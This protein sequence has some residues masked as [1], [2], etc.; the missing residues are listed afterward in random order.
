M[1]FGMQM[2]LNDDEIRKIFLPNNDRISK[3]TYKKYACD[4]ESDVHQYIMNRYA[5][6][7]SFKESVYRICWNIQEEHPRCKVC[8]KLVAIRYRRKD[9]YRT[10]CCSFCV[11]HDKG[12]LKKKEKTYFE[13]TGYTHNSRN[14]ESVNKAKETCKEKY[15]TE[16][17]CQSDLVKSKSMKTCLNRYGVKYGGQSK[18]KIQKVKDTCLKKYGYE[19]SL[20]NNKVQEKRKQTCKERLGV[21]WPSQNQEVK[22]KLS[23]IH[24]SM[25]C[26]LKT[27]ETKRK[28]KTFNSSHQEQELFDYIKERFQDVKLQY[29][30]DERYPFNCDFYIPELDL[31]IEFN[32]TWTHGKH[33]YNCKSKEDNSILDI[34]KEKAKTSKFYSNAIDTWTIRDVN[35]RNKA[36]ENNLN[37]KE[38]WNLEEAKKFVDNIYENLNKS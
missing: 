9:F 34:W 2:I 23:N 27:N 36:K 13:K 6:S 26:Q 31:F 38:V 24:K 29:N 30:M 1:R 17:A 3:S 21:C 18:Q 33:A 10:Y 35:K 32:G 7:L 25:E 20:S 28:N 12:I 37:Y 8:G 15:G 16:W 19:C 11:Q 5:D 14:P 22:E 4:K